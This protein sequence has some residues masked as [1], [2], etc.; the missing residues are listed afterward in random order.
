MNILSAGAASARA[1]TVMSASGAMAAVTAKAVMTLVKL[2]GGSGWRSLPASMT[3]PVSTSTRAQALGS[4]G[5]GAAVVA[6]AEVTPGSAGRAEAAGTGP[7]REH[8]HGRKGQDRGAAGEAGVLECG[9][10]SRAGSA[11]RGMPGR[12]AA[13]VEAW[14]ATRG[15]RRGRY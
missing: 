13:S 14:T 1:L 15:W 12:P 2:A 10:S 9:E 11:G 3:L 8:Q 4:G 7:R 5:A 6:V